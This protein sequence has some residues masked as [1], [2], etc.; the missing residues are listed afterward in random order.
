MALQDLEGAEEKPRVAVD[1]QLHHQR[2]EEFNSLLH[3]RNLR[4]LLVQ[5]LRQFFLP[6][7]G[8]VKQV[9]LGIGLE[10]S[11]INSDVMQFF[12]I[13]PLLLLQ[14]LIKSHALSDEV[15]EPKIEDDLNELA[16]Q[17]LALDDLLN[18]GRGHA[19]LVLELLEFL[20]ELLDVVAFLFLVQ[21]VVL[22]VP[23]D[24]QQQRKD[25]VLLLFNG[26][27]AVDQSAPQEVQDGVEAHLHLQGLHFALLAVGDVAA[28]R[29]GQVEGLKPFELLLDELQDIVELLLLLQQLAL[30][31][32][33]VPVAV[34][35]QHRV[36]RGALDIGKSD[37]PQDCSLQV[38][39]SLHIAA[40]HFVVL[41]DG[42]QH[43]EDRGLLEGF[44]LRAV[45][46]GLGLQDLLDVETRRGVLA[47]AD[48]GKQ[49]E[50]GDE[51]IGGLVEIDPAGLLEEVLQLALG[52]VVLADVALD[53]HGLDLGLDRPRVV[54]HFRTV[55]VDGQVVQEGE[56]R[57]LVQVG[58]EVGAD[59]VLVADD[60]KIATDAGG[61]EDGEEL[62]VRRLEVEDVE[63]SLDQV[64][65][66]LPEELGDHFVVVLQYLLEGQVHRVFLQ[67]DG[68]VYYDL[69]PLLADVQFR[70]WVV[71]YDLPD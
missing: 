43:V 52:E 12:D 16:G 67:L 13:V 30:H 15:I 10:L 34:D 61:A 51:V 33:Q 28:T 64:V 17:R 26:P 68:V 59:E 69:Q 40:V 32:I 58:E 38:D 39:V 1:T 3:L 22:V 5:D 7:L 65:V 9:S 4:A 54:H 25:L 2:N 53:H 8:T 20:L 47:V 45:G 23:E 19:D 56:L 21:D 46:V 42:H 14:I 48:V 70:D 71:L 37:Q 62:L 41:Q 66:V 36:L 57:H 6:E 49:V 50:V 29:S 55:L 27:V 60:R 11:D 63:D 18:T 35:P 31:R 24:L 44:D